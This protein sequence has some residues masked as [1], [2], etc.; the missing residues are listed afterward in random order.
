MLK[1]QIK[2]R[3]GQLNHCAYSAHSASFEGLLVQVQ[4]H[5]FAFAHCHNPVVEKEFIQIESLIADLYGLSEGELH[6]VTLL[7]KLPTLSSLRVE[8]SSERDW[9][10]FSEH[11][12]FVCSNFCHQIGAVAIGQKYLFFLPGGEVIHFKAAGTSDLSIALSKQSVDVVLGKVRENTILEIEPCLKEKS[13]PIEAEIRLGTETL[14]LESVEVQSKPCG[15]TLSVPQANLDALN[16]VLSVP[17]IVAKQCKL[18]NGQKV[19][20]LQR[21]QTVNPTS[22]EIS[23]CSSENRNEIAKRLNIC[24]S[25][26]ILGPPKSG[27][28]SLCKEIYLKE[29]HFLEVDSLEE[30]MQLFPVG[31]SLTLLLDNAQRK[32]KENSQF[33]E[34]YLKTLFKRMRIHEEGKKLKLAFF[35]DSSVPV[36]KILSSLFDEQFT[37]QPPTLP[38]LMHHFGGNVGQVERF[39][40]RSWGYIQRYTKFNLPLTPPSPMPQVIGYEG[41]KQA[42]IEAI[43]W[44]IKYAKL[45][46]KASLSRKEGIVLWGP[47]G[48]GKSLLASKWLPNHPSIRLGEDSLSVFRVKGPAL[49]GKYIGAS[50]EAIRTLFLQASQSAPSLI[51]LEEVDALAPPRGNDNSGATDRVVNQLLTELDGVN[52]LEGVFVVATTTRLEGIDPALLRA[53]R[54]GMHI[55]VDMPNEKE[56]RSLA[57]YYSNAYSLGEEAELFIGDNTTCAAIE[58]AALARAMNDQLLIEASEQNSKISTPSSLQACK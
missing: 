46:Q 36:P 16:H 4:D 30:A 14:W 32:H 11:S 18:F 35:W 38:E 50:E 13:E 5:K 52:V 17:F 57:Q 41:V 12:E 28:S 56:R 24:D 53:G 20:I 25:L 8:A 10:L 27:K 55:Q 49:L 6:S 1:A 54:L 51:V 37:I 26:L 22:K 9:K 15:K 19:Q 58:S 45:Y 43:I 33:F 39:H 3:V 34:F 47:S 44:P 21:E 48:C 23:S 31:H 42:L 29:M 7:S 40:G 2:R